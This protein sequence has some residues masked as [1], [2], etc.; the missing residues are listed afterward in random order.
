M[1]TELDL[2][3]ESRNQMGE[4]EAPSDAASSDADSSEKQPEFTFMQQA[5]DTC[6]AGPNVG[7]TVNLEAFLEASKHPA[8]APPLRSTAVDA[9]SRESWGGAPGRTMATAQSNKRASF[10]PPNVTPDATMSFSGDQ[11]AAGLA[12]ST[13]TAKPKPA[14]LWHKYV[15]FSVGSL[16]TKVIGR[17]GATLAARVFDKHEFLNG[18]TLNDV[19]N[20]QRDGSNRYLNEA[21]R[22][23]MD[24]HSAPGGAGDYNIFYQAVEHTQ[25]WWEQDGPK[26]LQTVAERMAA[27]ENHTNS[28]KE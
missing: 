25:R 17:E 18:Y 24:K 11:R 2:Y 12:R 21:Q 10:L 7:G 1:Q 9:G 16:P 13:D 15:E 23:E 6:V 14:D 8:P 4:Q 3:H 28:G 27:V 20:L 22:K 26:N 19:L 5:V